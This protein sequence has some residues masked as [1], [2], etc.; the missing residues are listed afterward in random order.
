M[1]K[2]LSIRICHV[3][4]NSLCIACAGAGA[5]AGA[6]APDA[7]FSCNINSVCSCTVCSS[8]LA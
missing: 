8:P 6:I 2:N 1:F 7:I 5:D 3:G 4:L